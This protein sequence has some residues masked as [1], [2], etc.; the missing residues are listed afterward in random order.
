MIKL[1]T[2]VLCTNNPHFV[3]FI[4]FET[5]FFKKLLPHVVFVVVHKPLHSFP[6]CQIV[7]ITIH[8]NTMAQHTSHDLWVTWI[9]SSTIIHNKKN[10]NVNITMKDVPICQFA[11]FFGMTSVEKHLHV[12]MTPLYP[13][14]IWVW[15][16]ST[17]SFSLSNIKLT[18]LSWCKG[19][20]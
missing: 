1:T 18:N 5:C 16:S 6:M 11:N 19:G 15:N 3:Y 9:Y 7:N 13:L 8:Y 10:P 20:L 4:N 2:L 14:V 12:S 17:L